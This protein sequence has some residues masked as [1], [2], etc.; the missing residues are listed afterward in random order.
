MRS[1]SAS[2]H[3][4]HSLL[5]ESEGHHGKLL[6]MG[7]IVTIVPRSFSRTR[8]FILGFSR[9]AYMGFLIWG[10]VWYSTTDQCDPLH[11]YLTLAILIQQLYLISAMALILM[12]GLLCMMRSPHSPVSQKTFSRLKQEVLNADMDERC[13]ICIEDFKAGDVATHL[14]CNHRFHPGCVEPWL[15]THNTCP[16]CRVPVTEI[17]EDV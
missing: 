2:L 8:K 16:L 6:I 10:Q 1:S 3:H 17:L 14:A 12:I 11:R 7:I 13:A 15:R 4:R 5:S 9:L